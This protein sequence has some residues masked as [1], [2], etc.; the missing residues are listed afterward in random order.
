[1]KLDLQVL[2]FL[3][4]RLRPRDKLLKAAAFKKV[5]ANYCSVLKNIAVEV[6]K[7]PDPSALYKAH[8]GA[9]TQRSNSC[10]FTALLT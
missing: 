6:R 5:A 9:F 10:P 2:K 1:M 8:L 4:N 3:I 7:L